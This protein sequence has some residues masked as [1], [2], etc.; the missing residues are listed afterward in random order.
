MLK[1]DLILWVKGLRAGDIG[2]VT[3]ARRDAQRRQEEIRNELGSRR[4]T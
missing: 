2:G 4:F 1:I 3:Q